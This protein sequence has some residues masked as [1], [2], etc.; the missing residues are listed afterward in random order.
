[1]GSQVTPVAGS[2]RS[3]APWRYGAAWT[4]FFLFTPVAAAFLVALAGRG[5]AGNPPPAMVGWLSYSVGCWITVYALWRWSLRRVLTAEIFV[6][7][8]PALLDAA[9]AV[10]GAVLGIFLIYPASQWV[11]HRLGAGML[12]M[13]FDLHR[14]LVLPAVIIWAIVTAP[15]CEEILFRGLAVAYLRSRGWP[16]LA[17][18]LV[19]S[20]AFAAIH[21]P[22][23]GLGG[24]IFILPWG[25]MLIAV[26]LWRESLTPGWMLHVINN[27]VA[28]LLIPALRGG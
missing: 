1:M 2:D 23:F 21:L 4:I 28:Y 26:R 8:R 12:G 20:L 15:L 17:V 5:V 13:R 11:A 3:R 10:G 14:D 7:R 6:F 16:V 18:A 9:L 27:L 22:Y 24:A 19:P 25:V